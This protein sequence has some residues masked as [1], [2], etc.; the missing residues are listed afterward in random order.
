MYV[1]NKKNM[2]NFLSIHENRQAYNESISEFQY[3]HVAYISEEDELIFTPEMPLIVDN[4]IS[5]THTGDDILV[6]FEI[7]YG[8]DG[9]DVETVELPVTGETW[10]YEWTGDTFSRIGSWQVS[11]YTA[12]KMSAPMLKA[13]AQPVYTLTLDHFGLDTSECTSVNNWFE[14]SPFS[15]VNISG[16]DVSSAEEMEWTFMNTI[17]ESIDMSGIDMSSIIL[18]RSLFENAGLLRTINMDGTIFNSESD[19]KG[20][21][22]LEYSDMFYGVPSD[23]SISLKNSDAAT[24]EILQDALIG[25]GNCYD[26]TIDTGDLIWTYNQSTGEWEGNTPKD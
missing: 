4:K 24:L 21:Y 7:G 17:A 9:K 5:G 3:P 23:V 13:A 25:T 20:W 11:P 2:K 8:V 12:A 15:S 1:Q 19:G 6:T 10:E 26:A 18:V 14:S 16:L 22:V